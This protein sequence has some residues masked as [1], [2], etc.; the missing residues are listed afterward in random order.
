MDADWQADLERWLDPF[1][2][3]LGNKTTDHVPSL[4]CW[5]DRAGR[6]QKHPAD[7]RQSR[8]DQL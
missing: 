1:L 7:G 4:Y 3:G 6:L 5:I 2:K 8:R